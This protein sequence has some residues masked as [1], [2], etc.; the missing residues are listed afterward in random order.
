MVVS[1]RKLCL[2]GFAFMREKISIIGLYLGVIASC[3][4]YAELIVWGVEVLTGS[5]GVH[6]F[7]LRGFLYSVL[8]YLSIRYTV[9]PCQ[10]C[11]RCG[12]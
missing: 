11:V 7:F 8:V 4:F 9:T 6:F 3:V 1:F 12:R 2:K 5:S 10:C